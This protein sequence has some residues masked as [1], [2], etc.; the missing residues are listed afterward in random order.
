MHFKETMFTKILRRRYEVSY[1]E[2]WSARAFKAAVAQ[3]PD[4]A[5]LLDVNVDADGE[6][7]VES[8]V[9]TWQREEPDRI[10]RPPSEDS[11]LG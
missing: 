9:L 8:F 3:L 2:G 5:E 6:T 11:T 4:D 10:A 1:R 7:G